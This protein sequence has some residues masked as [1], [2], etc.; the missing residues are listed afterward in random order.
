MINLAIVE[1]N[2]SYVQTLQKI[3][4]LES[5]IVC[6]K[7]YFNAG[8]AYADKVGLVTIDIVILDIQLPD[9]SGLELLIQ[10]KDEFPKKIFLI[11]TVYEDE[12]KLFYALKSGANGYILKSDTPATIIENI[13]LAS[14]GGAPMSSSIAKKVVHYF[15]ATQEKKKMLEE[16]S[17][18]ENE[19]LTHLSKGLLYK[20]IADIQNVTIDTIKKHCGSIYRKLQ[21]C[22]RTE[23]LNLY[24]NH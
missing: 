2:K 11:L 24:Y 18:K 8:D 12:D 15:H 5:D 6:P 14:Q 10:L 20:E 7:I 23:A 13:R 16:L 1:D 3:L 4:H 17:P 9:Y 22:N 19:I 21:V